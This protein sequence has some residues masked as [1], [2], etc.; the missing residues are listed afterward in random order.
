MDNSS[1]FIMES[2]EPIRELTINHNG[3]VI[4]SIIREG[5]AI[6]TNQYIKKRARCI[7]K[8]SAGCNNCGWRCKSN[9]TNEAKIKMRLHKKVCFNE[10]K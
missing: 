3:R 6:I 10:K 2:D 9:N 5:G 8:E 1:K 4:Q 7:T